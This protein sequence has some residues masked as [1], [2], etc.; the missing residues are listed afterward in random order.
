[1]SPWGHETQKSDARIIAATNR[2]LAAL[3]AEG[4]FREDL[5]YRINVIKLT[6][7]RWPTGAKI[8]R[9]RGAFY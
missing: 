3:M 9:C 6:L 7:P 8:Y 4:K 5:Y 2:D 1:M